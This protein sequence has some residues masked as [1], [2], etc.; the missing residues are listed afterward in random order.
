[1]L[2][3]N[4]PVVYIIHPLST[5]FV[6]GVKIKASGELELNDS[7]GYPLVRWVQFKPSGTF[8]NRY[9]FKASAFVRPTDH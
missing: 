5:K 2:W 6:T 8:L 7:P 1:M 4:L 9:Y 3:M